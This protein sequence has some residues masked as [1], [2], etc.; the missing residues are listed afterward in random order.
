MNIKLNA[1]LTSIT[2]KD[3]A[4]CAAEWVKLTGVTPG[5]HLSTPFLRKAISFER[6]CK[7]LGG[8]SAATRREL[9]RHIKGKPATPNDVNRTEASS[10]GRALLAGNQLVREWNGRVYRV[11][12][13]DD[14]FELDGRTYRSLSA[15]ARHITGAAWS[16]PRFFGLKRAS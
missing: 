13:L 9:G 1:E 16:G 11:L 5:Q 6:Q 12:V 15:V 3:R 14:G 7:V 4:Q 10:A 2:T 8:H